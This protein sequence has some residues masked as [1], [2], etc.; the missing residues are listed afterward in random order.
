MTVGNC[1]PMS[2]KTNPSSRKSTS[3]QTAPVCSRL[4]PEAQLGLWWPMMSPATTTAS[5]PET[6]S[7][8]P[9]R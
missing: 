8:S 4:A 7:A 3:R 1:W 2:R 5:T 9:S 6:C